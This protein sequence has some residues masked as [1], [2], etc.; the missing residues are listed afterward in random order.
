MDAGRASA[1]SNS[2][3]VQHV[4]I[5]V[6]LRLESPETGPDPGGY[7][8]HDSLEFFFCHFR[9]TPRKHRSRLHFVPRSSH[10]FACLS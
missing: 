1:H 8:V 3:R 4:M 6:N 2:S 10:R 9:A 5:A 7:G